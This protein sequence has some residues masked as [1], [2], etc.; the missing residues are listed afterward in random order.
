MEERRSSSPP[1]RRKATRDFLLAFPDR[2]PRFRRIGRAERVFTATA[3]ALLILFTIGW[4]WSI[5]RARAS[6]DAGIVT[7]ATAR[8][9]A[10]LTEG[11][12]PSVAYLTEAAL[13]ALAAPARG[14]SGKLR[15]RIQ[16]E[17]SPINPILADTL[18]AGATATFSSG[19]AAE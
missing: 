7:P 4:S 15:V 17:G 2:R 5:A 14:E 6:G 3:V 1:P 10:A 11:S 18:P 12:A 9:T 19:A 8:I 16:P 13:T